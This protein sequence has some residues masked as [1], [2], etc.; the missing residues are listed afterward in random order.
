MKFRF[1]AFKLGIIMFIV[2]LVQLTIESFTDLFVLNQ[3]AWTQLWRFLTAIFL[4]GSILHLL[5]NLFALV[6]FGSI[7][8]KL[9]GGR[10]FLWIF[11]ISGIL[12]NIIA[13]NFYDSSLGASGAIFGIIGALIVIRPMLMVWAFGRPMPIFVAHNSEDMYSYK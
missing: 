13:V 10:K 1:Y 3:I 4:H 11:F 7:L 6:L 12:A 2:F 5:Y 9:I 8:E